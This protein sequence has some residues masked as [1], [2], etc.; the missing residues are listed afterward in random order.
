MVPNRWGK[1]YWRGDEETPRDSYHVQM[2]MTELSSGGMNYDIFLKTLYEI[3]GGEKVGL[4][5]NDY[6]QWEY[7]NYGVNKLHIENQGVYLALADNRYS[8]FKEENGELVETYDVQQNENGIDIEDRVLAGLRLLNKYLHI[9]D[10]DTIRQYIAK[11]DWTFARTMP[12]WPQE[13]IVKDKCIL[14]K[15]EFEHFVWT[16]RVLGKVEDWGPYRQPYLY[17]DGY[18]YWT[19]GCELE[20]TTVI[21]RAKTE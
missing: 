4:E 3:A 15:E 20:V 6:S 16:Q 17:L 21:N 10:E 9:Y 7:N 8:I 1:Y 19:M 14:T 13:Y 2:M 12:Q 5:L 18:K 11:C